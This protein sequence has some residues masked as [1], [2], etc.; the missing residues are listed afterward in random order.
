MEN[1][2]QRAAAET[3][4]EELELCLERIAVLRN[5]LS[6]GCSEAMTPTLAYMQDEARGLTAAIYD[7]LASRRKYYRKPE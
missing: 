6:Q 1:E 3:P 5:R 2:K 4:A 7:M